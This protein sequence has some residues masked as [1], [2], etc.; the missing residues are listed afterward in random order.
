MQI[1]KADAVERSGGYP[2]K[3]QSLKGAFEGNSDDNT[4]DYLITVC[5]Q[6]R[7]LYRKAVKVLQAAPAQQLAGLDVFCG[8]HV[9]VHDGNYEY[10]EFWKALVE[11]LHQTG[12]KDKEQP[13]GHE[14]I[15]SHYDGGRNNKAK[16]GGTVPQYEI[17]FPGDFGCVLFGKFMVKNGGNWALDPTQKYTWFQVEGAPVCKFAH[18][19]TT[20]S[21]FATGMSKN[22]GSKGKSTYTDGHPVHVTRAALPAPGDPRFAG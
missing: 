1:T 18:V 6:V 20:I 7:Y 5:N 12:K 4:K 14:R 8:A 17:H 10:Y 21:Y 13:F 15:S 16:P 19:G 11:S 22:I 3:Y 9:V 2:G